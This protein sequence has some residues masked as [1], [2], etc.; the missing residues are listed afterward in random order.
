MTE[1]AGTVHCAQCVHVDTGGTHCQS[2]ILS[3]SYNTVINTSE[4]QLTKC[5]FP[6]LCSFR[7]WFQ[8]R[9]RLDRGQVVLENYSIYPRA[10][11]I[12]QFLNRPKAHTAIQAPQW[13]QFHLSLPS[14]GNNFGLRRQ[15][16]LH[17]AA[18]SN[19]SHVLL[20]SVK[21]VSVKAAIFIWEEMLHSLEIF[22]FTMS[23]IWQN[24]FLLFTKRGT[25]WSQIGPPQ[26]LR[27][28]GVL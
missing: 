28:G 6:H 4:K 17:N 1:C 15:L 7:S 9:V 21:S 5:S 3:L 25:S 11:E 20:K 2:Q 12:V 13:T 16:L 26:A 23:I 14:A 24:I 19:W 10:D 8:S 22:I 27:P 18:K